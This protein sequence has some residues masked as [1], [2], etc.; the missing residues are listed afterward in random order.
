MPQA[1]RWSW[2]VPVVAMFAYAWAAILIRWAGEASP[3]VIAFY[4]MAI[5][6]VVWAPFYALPTRDSA[7]VRP[8]RRQ[9]GL[10]VLA[11]L[12]LCLH[13]A[14]WISSL[15]YTTVSSSVFLIL[16]QPFMVAIAAHFILRE[17]LGRM[18]MAAFALT[19]AGSL[20]IFG[21]DFRLGREY[22]FGDL[23]ALI[24]AMAAGGYLLCA[25]LVR[26]EDHSGEP[27]IPLQR[28]LPPVYAVSAVG[29][30]LLALLHGDSFGPF[31]HQ[32][33]LALLALGLVPTVIGHSLLNWSMRYLSALAVN[34]SLVG[35]PIGASLL[36]WF[37]LHEAPSDGL[38]AGSPLLVLAVVLVFLRPPRV[39]GETL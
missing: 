38:L 3:F 1:P 25:R 9:W 33:W 13:F 4:R 37:L 14:T 5:A 22:L 10:M 24:G 20:L 16:T 2:V 28:Y 32:T 29:L 12:M 7:P 11:G 34:I 30:G 6:T 35:E 21:G 18:H 17:R 19:L 31:S 36:A 39:S 23:L 8:T 27:G 26:G 15:R